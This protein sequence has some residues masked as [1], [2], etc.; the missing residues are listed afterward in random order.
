MCGGERK[1]TLLRREKTYSAAELGPRPAVK[2]VQVALVE[3]ALRVERAVLLRLHASDT[4]TERRVESVLIEARDTEEV[5]DDA[6]RV[7]Y[8]REDDSQ[9]LAPAELG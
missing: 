9:C 2:R 8:V 4:V 7:Q 6:R 3:A 1:R 5:R